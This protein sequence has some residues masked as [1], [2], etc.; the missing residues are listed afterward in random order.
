MGLK[1]SA[2][3]RSPTWSEL[4]LRQSGAAGAGHHIDIRQQPQPGRSIAAEL[5]T[6]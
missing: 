5:V 1:L 4:I 6:T 3:V 2:T